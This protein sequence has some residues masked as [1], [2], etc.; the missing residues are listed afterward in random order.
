[1][2]VPTPRMCT[3]SIPQPQYN[4]IAESLTSFKVRADRAEERYSQRNRP[5]QR[6]KLCRPEAFGSAVS[7]FV[8]ILIL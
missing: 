8:N 2:G 6:A 5:S 7:H 1:M 4:F 3:G